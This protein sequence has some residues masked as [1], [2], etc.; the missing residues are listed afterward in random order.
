MFVHTHLPAH[1][2]RLKGAI[3]WKWCIS[4]SLWLKRDLCDCWS[5]RATLR[6]KDNTVTPTSVHKLATLSEKL[7]SLI[8]AFD[9]MPKVNTATICSRFRTEAELDFLVW[10]TA[11]AKSW[12][13]FAS[14]PLT[15]YMHGIFKGIFAWPCI[16]L[17][18]LCCHRPQYPK[19]SCLLPVAAWQFIGSLQPQ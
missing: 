11:V 6:I 12:L 15:L 9:L 4:L 10:L 16:F 13:P 7:P 17:F 8:K 5:A 2:N 1:M 18:F 3:C 19:Y 14:F